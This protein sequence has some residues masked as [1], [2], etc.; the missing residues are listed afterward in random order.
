MNTTHEILTQDVCARDH[1]NK[2]K[3]IFL[4][5]LNRARNDKPF[6][7]DLLSTRYMLV[8]LV[9]IAKDTRLLRSIPPNY[10]FWKNL[11][12]YFFEKRDDNCVMG[13]TLSLTFIAFLSKRE[14]INAAWY[15]VETFRQIERGN[16]IQ[17]KTITFSKCETT[18]WETAVIPQIQRERPRFGGKNTSEKYCNIHNMALIWHY[19]ILLLFHSLKKPWGNSSSK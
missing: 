9:H 18:A 1:K 19:Q 4:D 17:E 2:R 6:F 3:R 10:E 16:S 14:S 13:Y 12:D 5:Y 7:E 11:N 8:I 15:Y